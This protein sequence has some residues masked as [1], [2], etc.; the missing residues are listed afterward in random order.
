MAL[1]V[2]EA[3]AHKTLISYVYY[4]PGTV[5]LAHREWSKCAFKGKLCGCST[6][7][8]HG[9]DMVAQ[10][11]SSRLT[12]CKGRICYCKDSGSRQAQLDQCRDNLLHFVRQALTPETLARDV[13]FLFNIV[14]ATQAPP[15]LRR[16]AEAHPGRI[17]VDSVPSAVTDLCTQGGVVRGNKATYDRFMLINCSA[18]GPYVRDWLGVFEQALDRTR[19][20]HL[21]GPSVNCWQ[22]QPHVQSWVW[23][24]DGVAADL[25]ADRCVCDGKRNDQIRECELGVS[26]A[27]LQQRQNFASLQKPYAGYDWADEKHQRCNYGKSP[28]ACSKSDPVLSLGCKGFEPCSEVFVKF[29]GNN[30]ALGFMP[31]Q[32]AANVAVLD[33][34]P[35]GF[36]SPDT[37]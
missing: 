14:G 7:V 21:V 30:L 35:T 9:E 27:L 28:I 31:V 18:R 17:T 19:R 22:K 2:P 33:E 4:H 16:A 3:S 32:A 10:N 1:V 23:Y 20:V 25:I 26:S 12:P 13:D 6:M 15:E 5:P 24:A 37:V 29:G 34:S 36:C 11:V 8:K